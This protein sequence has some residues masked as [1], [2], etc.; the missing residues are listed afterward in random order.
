L[1]QAAERDPGYALA[2]VG[3]AN[4][5]SSL[6]YYGMEPD[7]ARERAGEAVA[8]AL[9]L[10][11]D[12]PEAH[13][14]R[15]LMQTWLLWDWEGAEE[16]FRR[17]IRERPEDA[18]AHC[19]YGFL[20]DSLG[21]HEEGL[22]LAE[23]A[24]A[25]DP[26]SS[27]ANT[28]VGLSLFTGGEDERAIAALGRALEVDPDF[29]YTLWVLGGTYLA[30]GRHDEAT[31][32]LERAVTL[33]DRASYYVTWLAYAHGVAGRRREAESLIGELTERSKAEY[34]SPTFFAWAHTGRGDRN[35]ALDWLEKA[36]DERSPPLVMHQATLLRSLHSEPRF[37]AVQ[38]RMK[39]VS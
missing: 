13:A 12:L 15:G 18:L 10:A 2:H 25:L 32:A 1:G 6:G 36:C 21:R 20:L 35:A 14:A 3:L 11:P 27:Y 7:R 26:L 23:K 4:A 19:W 33:S 30:G 8:R 31:A 39:I 34:V 22:A 9:E 17:A 28:C 38:E 37:R 24:L 16:S 29:L 5:Y